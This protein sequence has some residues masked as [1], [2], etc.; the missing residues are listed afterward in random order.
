MKLRSISKDKKLIGTEIQNLE[1]F[2]V[3]PLKS[4]F[5]NIFV[6]KEVFEPVR[7]YSLSDVR[8]KMF[9]VQN[10]VDSYVFF[11]LLHSYQEV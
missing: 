10:T 2:Y 11:P 1:D 6:G 3:R 5:L 9:A 7:S 4:S 8:S